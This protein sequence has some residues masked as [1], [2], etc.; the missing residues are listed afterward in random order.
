MSKTNEQTLAFSGTWWVRFVVGWDA[1]GP[2]HPSRLP[3]LAFCLLPSLPCPI[4][5][6]AFIVVSHSVGGRQTTHPLPVALLVGSCASLAPMFEPFGSILLLH[7]VAFCVTGT[8]SY[9][10][11][12]D[13]HCPGLVPLLFPFVFVFGRF[14]DN[15]STM[16]I[17]LGYSLSSQ[18]LI[19]LSLSLC[20]SPIYPSVFFNLSLSSLYLSLILSL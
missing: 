13:P 2:I 11:P 5:A 10:V 6:H 16:P 18:F 17:I 3:C 15:I 1:P 4:A 9:A 12:L 14:W 7:S 20:L 19:S 8:F